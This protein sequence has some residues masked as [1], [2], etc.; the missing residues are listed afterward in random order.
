M[1]S[2]LPVPFNAASTVAPDVP[3]AVEP[4]VMLLGPVYAPA[5]RAT[6]NE[7]VMRTVIRR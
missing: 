7:S 6:P 2:A 4:M 5:V 1:T 3:D